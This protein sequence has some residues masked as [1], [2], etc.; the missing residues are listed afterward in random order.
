[1]CR[2]RTRAGKYIN[3]CIASMILFSLFGCTAFKDV[4]GGEGGKKTE[5]RRGLSD[6][7]LMHARRLFILGDYEGALNEYQKILTTS[8]K[9]PPGDQAL[10][11]MGLIYA[12]YKYPKKDY[13]KSLTLFKRI[14]TDYP[15]SLLSEQADIWVG[16]LQV[17][18]E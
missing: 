4:K 3:I 18:E 14:L 13:K 6:K 15:M 11:N 12:H 5:V 10:F 16:V 1:M 8:D 9:K 2:Q 17:I 7:D